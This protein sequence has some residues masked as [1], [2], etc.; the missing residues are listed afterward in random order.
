MSFIGGPLPNIGS[1]SSSSYGGAGNSSQEG[2]FEEE[3]KK[4]S[5]RPARMQKFAEAV[6]KSLKY[7]QQKEVDAEIGVK[8]DKD[9]DLAAASQK[10]FKISPDSTVVSGYTD[11]GFTLEGVQGRSVLG[12]VG[13]GLTPFFPVTGQAIGAVGSLTGIYKLTNLKILIKG[14]NQKHWRYH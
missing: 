1:S 9:K 12:A 13:A 2:I 3:K 4:D 5:N 6:D 7:K 8:T 14:V 11:P 10:G